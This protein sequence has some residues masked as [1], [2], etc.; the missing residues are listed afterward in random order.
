MENYMKKFCE[1]NPKFELKCSNPNCK[2]KGTHT[3]N[4]IDVLQKENFSFV[5]DDTTMN[6]DTTDLKKAIKKSLEML[7]VEV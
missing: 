6:Y 4:S 2:Y 7:G 3:F 1:Q 5:C